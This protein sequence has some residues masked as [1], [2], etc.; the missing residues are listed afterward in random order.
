MALPTRKVTRQALFLS[1]ALV[2]QIVEALLIPPFSIPGLRLGLANVATLAVLV[3]T[4]FSDA[5]TLSLMRV[6]L[7]SFLLATFGTTAFWLSLF[8]ALAS[9][10]VM[11]LLLKTTR[12][13]FGFLGISVCGAMAHNLAQLFTYSLLTRLGSWGNLAPLLALA[14]IPTGMGVAVMAY[15]L[16]KVEEGTKNAGCAL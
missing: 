15:G 11:G 7:A 10:I 5:V 4:G 13:R 2:L 8:G 12:P 6:L 16:C 1:L 14:A 9:V 3:S